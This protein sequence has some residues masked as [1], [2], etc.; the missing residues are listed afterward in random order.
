MSTADPGSEKSFLRRLAVA[1]QPALTKI[2]H[3]SA[4]FITVFALIHLTAPVMANLGGT[5]LA[6]QVMLVGREYYQTPFGEKYLVLAP[7]AIHPIS[8]TLKRLLAPTT[9]RRITSILSLTGYSAAIIVALH[10]FTHRIAPSDPAPPIY[11]VGPS[12]L[13]YEYVKFALHSWP[14]RGFVSY[15]GLAALVAWHAAEGMAIIWNT[16]A[17]PTFGPLRQTARSRAIGAVIGI[18]PVATGLYYMWQ[19]PLMIFASHAAR[20]KAAFTKSVYFQL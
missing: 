10:L 13:D 3:G 20:F 14:W 9:A 12:E 8:A 6:S 19:E 11:S 5:S 2:A 16:W 7:L 18:L 15:I 17:R 1:T 4:P